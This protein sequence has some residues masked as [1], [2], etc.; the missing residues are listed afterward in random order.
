METTT[1]MKTISRTEPPTLK[2]HEPFQ[3]MLWLGVAG[4]MLLFTALIAIY[5][6]KQAGQIVKSAPLPTE[7]LISTAMILL[8]S[9]TLHLAN[10]AFRVERFERYRYLMATTILLGVG[11]IL[12]QFMGWKQLIEQG[13]AINSNN[14]NAFIYILSGL[15]I[16]HILGGIIAVSYAFVQ[17]LKNLSYIDSFVYSVNPPNQLKIKLITRYWHFVDV[18]WIFLLGFL[19]FGRG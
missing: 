14:A 5:V 11:F 15:H 4:S 1:Q 8:S 16:L 19:W 10:I 12:L 3:F 18:L 13:A 9:L 7:F 6:V 17:S 2:R